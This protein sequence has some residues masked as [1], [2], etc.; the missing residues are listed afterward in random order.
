[1]SAETKITGQIHKIMPVQEISDS[2]TKRDI[3]VKTG[4][5]YPQLISIQFVQDQ[6][7]LFN[8]I[9]EGANVVVDVNIRGREWTNPSTGEVKYFNTLQGWKI[10][11]VNN[12][13]SPKP[14]PAPAPKPIG[15]IE[16]NFQEDAINQMQE[17]DDLP[18]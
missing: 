4:G 1:M 12:A 16:A 5:D 11:Q 6:V 18:F 9:L 10:E 3:V 2:F 14:Q 7:F 8:D 17:E 13:G 15:N